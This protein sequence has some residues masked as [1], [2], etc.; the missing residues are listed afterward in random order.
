MA[1][2][3]A[4]VPEVEEQR[5]DAPRQ[6]REACGR[7]PFSVPQGDERN[8]ETQ[9]VRISISDG[10]QREVRAAGTAEGSAIGGE[11]TPPESVNFLTFFSQKR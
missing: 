11:E 10:E 7:V 1:Q 9:T 6:A 8:G 4:E 5:P 3:Q 2:E